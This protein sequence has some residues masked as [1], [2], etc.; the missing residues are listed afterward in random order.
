MLTIQHE[1][2]REG[3]HLPGESS[4]SFEDSSCDDLKIQREKKHPFGEKFFS[5]GKLDQTNPRS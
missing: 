5:F 3:K 4:L 1:V 2:Q